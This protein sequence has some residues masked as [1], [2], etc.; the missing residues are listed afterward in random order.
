MSF[1]YYMHIIV[2]V[3][4][5]HICVLMYN[6]IYN[7]YMYIYLLSTQGSQE[8]RTRMYNNLVSKFRGRLLRKTDNGIS[9]EL[10]LVQRSAE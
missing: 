1:V 4:Y 5:T 7:T 6:V 8:K 3:I 2:H 9:T 10:F